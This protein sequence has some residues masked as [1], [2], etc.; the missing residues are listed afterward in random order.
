MNKYS[1]N[2]FWSDED[3]GFI[4]VSPEFPGLSAFGKTPEKAMIEAQVALQLFMETYEEEGLPLPEPHKA[5]QYS[6][7]IR[8]RFPKSLHYQLAR[9]AEI[10]ETS[11]NSIIVSA[12]QSF[13]SGDF[14]VR[15]AI[16]EMKK[17]LDDHK[18]ALASLGWGR[19]SFKER[20]VSTERELVFAP[21]LDLKDLTKGGN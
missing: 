15:R 10:D 6:G 2:V 20:T 19:P 7:Q 11:L 8:V 14:S 18:L 21:G 3:E 4:A 12:C 17:L 5:Q 1:F 13:V 9:R 16:G